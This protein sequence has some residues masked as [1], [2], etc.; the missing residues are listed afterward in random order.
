MKPSR[1]FSILLFVAAL[2]VTTLA[3]GG[4]A[5][6]P[7]NTAPP[8]PTNT[9]PPPPTNTPLPPPTNT[10]IPPPTNTPAP[11]NGTGPN[12]VA[13][14]INV[15]EVSG[16][17]DESNYWYLF[18]LVSNDTDRA[19]NDIEVEVQFL[20]ATGAVLY[21]LFSHWLPGNKHPS[22]STLMRLSLELKRSLL[23]WLAMALPISFAPTLIYQ[24]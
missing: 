12:I 2:V 21:S 3:C 11:N 7:T 10:P 18:G 14:Q 17:T 23:R 6:A 4:T 13:G 5:A 15:R 8:P 20:D 1:R 24:V 16:F 22:F 19:V 9:L